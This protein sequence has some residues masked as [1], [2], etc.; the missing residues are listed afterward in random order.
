LLDRLFR[1]RRRPEASGPRPL[2]GPEALARWRYLVVTAPPEA[3]VAAHAAGLAALG[4]DAQ[5]EV[6]HRVRTALSALEPGAVAPREP[7]VLVRAAARAERRAP[8]FI[9]RALSTDVPGRRALT[10]L[11]S[12][13]VATGAAAP[14]LRGFEP[15]LGSDA[16][17]DG[18]APD[19]DADA[20]PDTHGAAHDDDLDDED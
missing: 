10:G 7:E 13:V 4:A 11:A 2:T 9:E 8:G 1:G 17:A 6:L 16:Q 19:L 15:E 12:A 20:F 18:G 3:L 5:G 14:F